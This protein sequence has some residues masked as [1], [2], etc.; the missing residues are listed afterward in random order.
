MN[1]S[2]TDWEVYYSVYYNNKIPKPILYRFFIYWFYK[3]TYFF[4]CEYVRFSGSSIFNIP[5]RN[6]VYFAGPLK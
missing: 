5:I 1:K 2:E 4:S 6:I 3:D